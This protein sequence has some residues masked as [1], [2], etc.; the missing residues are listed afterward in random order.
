MCPLQYHLLIQVRAKSQCLP[1][2]RTWGRNELCGWA[3][4]NAPSCP[5]SEHPRASVGGLVGAFVMFPHLC[6]AVVCLGGTRGPHSCAHPMRHGT[7]TSRVNVPFVTGKGIISLLCVLPKLDRKSPLPG[8]TPICHELMCF[9]FS[10]CLE[11]AACLLPK[12]N[13]QRHGI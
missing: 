12:V 5:F 8:V 7:H 2:Q 6:G 13:W 9:L 1:P 10:P 11:T 3:S 4:A